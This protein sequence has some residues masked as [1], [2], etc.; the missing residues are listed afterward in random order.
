MQPLP[1]REITMRTFKVIV[2]CL[3]LAMLALPVLAAKGH[4]AAAKQD[5]LANEVA[6]ITQVCNPT[7]DQQAKINDKLQAAQAALKDFDAKNHDGI[8]TLNASLKDARK[9]G[10]KAKIKD[11]QGQL[12]PLQD[13]R[14]GIIKQFNNDVTGLLTPDQQLTWNSYQLQ[15]QMKKYFAKAKLTDEQIAKIKLLCDDTAAA[16]A[17]LTADDNKGKA[18]LLRGLEAKIDN[19]ILTD[20]QRAAMLPAN[21]KT[22]KAK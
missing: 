20:D 21:A 3:L 15:Q 2:F 9:A 19:D 16:M 22:P 18:K 17:K 6:A 7:A 12:K 10:D 8:A 4:K 13:Q 5:P 11:L 1:E 14:T